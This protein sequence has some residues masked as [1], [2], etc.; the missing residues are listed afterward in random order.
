MSKFGNKNALFQ[1]F[2]ARILKNY[3]HI[4]N[5]HPPICQIAKFCRIKKNTYVLDQKYIIL[6][7]MGQNFLKNPLYLKSALSNFSNCNILQKKERKKNS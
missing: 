3:W 6:V 5:Q 2:S 1:N 4:W 7:F